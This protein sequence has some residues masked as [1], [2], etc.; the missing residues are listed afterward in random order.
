[1]VSRYERQ[2]RGDR[3]AYDRYVRGMDASM[4]QKVALTAA[5]LLGLGVVADMGTG[6][7]SASHALAS[8]YPALDVVGVDVNPQMAALA[9][10]HYQALNLRFVC[11]D[12]AVHCFLPE[13]LDGVF[14]SSVLHHV[15]S[16]SRYDY[17]AAERCL[18]T[19]VAELKTHGVLVVRDFVDPGPGDVLLDLPGHDGDDSDDP[20]RCSS[21][22]LFE[23]F[24]R[25]YRRLADSPGFRYQALTAGVESPPREGWRRYR[26]SRKLAVEFL[27]RK[28]YRTDWESEI[29]EEYTYFTQERFE[30]T[31]ARL[32]LR[33]LAS[34]PICN[35]WI[36]RNRLTGKF[37]WCE[38]AGGALEPP[39]TNY[40]IAGEKVA[41]GE[42]VAFSEEPGK[43]CGFLHLD[44]YRDRRTGQVRDLVRRPNLTLDV[45][46]WFAH[47]GDVYVLARRAYPRPI[48]RCRARGTTPIDGSR[49]VDY[50]TEPLIVLQ[51]DEPVGR[52]VERALLAL[53]GIHSDAILGFRTGHHYYPSPG[54]IEEEVRS[55]FVEVTPVFGLSGQLRAIEAVQLL[56]AAQVGALP[57]ARLELN[58]YT[59]LG[60]L[61]REPGAWLGE[62]ITLADGPA[63][64]VVATI[65]ALL[66]RPARRVFEK[67]DPAESAGFLELHA[68]EFAEHDSSGATLRSLALEFVIPRGL[69]YNT[70]AIAALLRHD[71][72]VFL[73]I[74]DDD[75]PAAQSFGGNSN[76]LVTPAW[77]LPS[78]L[79]S[80]GAAQAWIHER[81]LAEY[82][83]RCRGTWELGGRYHPAAGTTPEVVHALAVEVAEEQPA[84]RALT[85]VR[86]ADAITG[87]RS[88]KDG[89]LLT[90]VLR[91]GH[92]LLPQ[93]LDADRH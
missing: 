50:V 90:L 5:H 43:P 25:E 45:V 28:D 68:A 65:E 60:M 93:G 23:R 59:L 3:W 7:G 1:M 63:P 79:T 14:D 46:P 41:P 38:A 6:S 37:A 27:L 39:A 10:A 17:D 4:K 87:A 61:G 18:S 8:L 82:G 91:A 81:L 51:R 64:S 88:F 35:P 56:R 83:A 47:A 77:R 78:A 33:L 36:L 49:A 70:I 53:A 15:T 89:H 42:G 12:V 74:D 71:G 22:A 58:T 16:F 85:W 19:Q 72:E 57:D 69:S 66:A 31:F 34:T 32:G 20:R 29:L 40:L 9:R 30:E 54:G 62:E 44:H 52:T 21:A 13:S 55:L 48:L 84:G 76:L 92:A 86:L 80:R 67:A 2:D 24:A 11:A 73:G 75:L 26:V